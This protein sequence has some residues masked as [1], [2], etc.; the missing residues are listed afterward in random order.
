MNKVKKNFGSL[1]SFAK[2]IPALFLL[3]GAA[4]GCVTLPRS[5][6]LYVTPHDYIASASDIK[7][8][9]I[10]VGQ[11]DSIFIKTPNKK[12]ILVDA[13]GVP[14]WKGGGV[15][16]GRDY[17]I[18]VLQK[19]MPYNAPLD[20]V[21]MTHPHADHVG[22]MVSVLKDMKVKK[23]YDSGYARGDKEYADCLDV[24]KRKNIPYEIVSDGDELEIDP[25]VR[26]SVLSPPSGFHYEDAN[27]NSVVLRLEYKDFTILLTGDAE[28]EAE[29]YI[30][31]KHPKSRISSNVLK[32]PHHGSRSS[33]S[34]SF[35][36]ACQPEVAVISCGRSNQFGHPHSETLS[37]YRSIEAAVYRTDYDGDIAII[38]NGFNFTVI[39]SRRGKR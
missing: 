20:A 37:R 29:N 10:D 8:V 28:M 33:S 30:V 13:G 23:V 7:I 11:G 18:P 14:S 27:N 12:Y 1:P 17:V 19:N 34:P 36:A 26:I 38:S 3:V 39:P 25:D 35:I 4:G 16:T 32:S 9:V 2:I 21:V 24:I 31:S 22:G 15:D 5:Q 6:R